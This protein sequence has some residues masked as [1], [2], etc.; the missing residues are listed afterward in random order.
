VKGERVEF[1][2]GNDAS[3][4]VCI[5]HR[6][7]RFEINPKYTTVEAAKEFCRLVNAEYQRVVEEL[8]YWKAYADETANLLKVAH[9]EAAKQKAEVVAENQRLREAAQKVVRIVDET[10]VVNFGWGNKHDIEAI[11][12]LKAAL[13]K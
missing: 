5:F 8:E 12:E 4:W 2:T 7:G 6:N 3:E 13:G 9:E 11:N 10:K 1:V